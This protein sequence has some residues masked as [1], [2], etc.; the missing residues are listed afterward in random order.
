MLACDDDTL[1]RRAWA[2]HDL[3]YPRTP[4]G[5]LDNSDPECQ[6][7]GQGSRYAELLAA[8]VYAQLPKLDTITTE[9]R[10]RKYALRQRLS[11]IPALTFR[12]IV[13]PEGDAGPFLIMTWKDRK[14]CLRVVERTRKDGVRTGEFG[15]NNIPMTEW[16]LHIYYNNASLVNKRPMNNAG[17]PWNDPLNQFAAEYQYSKGTL[18]ALDGLI[19]RS[20]LLAIPPVLSDDAIDRVANAFRQAASEKS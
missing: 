17:R 8:V 12:R 9:M 6:L 7:W 10:R 2:C 5:R 19:D 3:G 20:S 11:S 14:T 1:Y 15:I 4:D 16:G 13:D 18:P